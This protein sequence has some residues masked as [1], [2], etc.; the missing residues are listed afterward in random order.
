MRM[1]G[2]R[3]AYSGDLCSALRR[4][5]TPGRVID[6]EMASDRHHLEGARTWRE[7]VKFDGHR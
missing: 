1:F 5:T 7:D 6:V 2:L 3:A 4:S